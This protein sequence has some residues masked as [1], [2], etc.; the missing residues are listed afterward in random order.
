MNEQ[1]VQL[2]TTEQVKALAPIS[3]TTRW[4]WV[5]AGLFPKPITI[6]RRTYWRRDEIQEWL[7]RQSAPK[8]S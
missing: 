6:A 7:E 2:L 5:K 4:R 3:H 8:A 1:E